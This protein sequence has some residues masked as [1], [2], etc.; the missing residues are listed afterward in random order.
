[1]NRKPDSSRLSAQ[2]KWQYDDLLN[3]MPSPRLSRWKTPAAE[4]CRCAT[5]RPESW[6]VSRQP[7]RGILAS[8]TFAAAA[9]AL[10]LAPL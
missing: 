5:M 9:P 2:T 4:P 3:F 8:W 1:L 6:R 7:K 10:L